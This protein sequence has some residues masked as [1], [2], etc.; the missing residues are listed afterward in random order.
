MVKE[1]RRKGERSSSGTLHARH[2]GSRYRSMKKVR[3]TKS[4]GDTRSDIR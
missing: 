3:A 4:A 2:L 1:L